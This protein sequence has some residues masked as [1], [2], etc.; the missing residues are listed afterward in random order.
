[1]RRGLSVLLC[2][3]LHAWIALAVPAQSPS[4]LELEGLP[5]EAEP[6]VGDLRFQ[7]EGLDLAGR[8]EEEQQFSLLE[9]IGGDLRNFYD[10]P[11]LGLIGVGVAGHALVSNTNADEWARAEYQEQIRSIGTDEVSEFVHG[12]KFFGEGT[13]VLPVF[14]AATLAGLPFDR[15]SSGGRVGEWGER[16]LRAVLVGGPPMLGLQYA[17][18]SSRP[19]ELDSASH[20]EPFKDT[21]AVSGHAFMGSIGFLSAAKMTDR[22]GLK[23]L[24]YAG[25]TLPA[26]SRINDDDHYASQVVLGWGLAYLAVSAVDDTYREERPY[27]LLP[28][29]VGDGLGVNVMF[30]Y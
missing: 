2:L 17:L 9:R 29:P 4:D 18:G 3:A 21:N 23:A 28:G 22:P 26:L 16:S 25:S 30:E 5:I 12:N 8:E 13:Y 24:L 11:T 19:G 1:M 15:D 10:A 20:W 6:D 14:A 7:F 27:R